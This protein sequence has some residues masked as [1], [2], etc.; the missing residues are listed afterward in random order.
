MEEKFVDI[1]HYV[2]VWYSCRKRK[3][4]TNANMMER[5]PDLFRDPEILCIRMNYN[6][7]HP[8]LVLEILVFTRF[9]INLK[10]LNAF[11]CFEGSL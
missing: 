9:K 11:L 4:D 5:N 6:F 1:I 2:Y 3:K 8:S 7:Y 10:L